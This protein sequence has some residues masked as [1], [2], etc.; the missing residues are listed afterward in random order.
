[1][2]FFTVFLQ[3]V[4]QTFLK[5]LKILIDR[6]KSGKKNA[7]LQVRAPMT[8]F[9]KC[10]RKRVWLFSSAGKGLEGSMSIEA[11]LGFSLFLFACVCM[12]A[13]MVMMDKQ[14][15]IQAD[16]ERKAEQLSQYAYLGGQG[17][18]A[19]LSD[20]ENI[21]LVMKYDMKLPFSVFGLQAIPME[22]KSVRRAWIGR[23]GPLGEEFEKGDR[24]EDKE[25]SEKMVFVG[26]NGTRYHKTASCHYLSNDIEAIAYEDLEI[27]RNGGGG[28][29]HPCRICGKRAG[30]GSTVYIMAEG[31]SYHSMR[32]CPATIAYIKEVPI[33]EVKHLGKCSYC[34]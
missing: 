5:N 8:G 7:T 28:R 27:R 6:M 9:C 3:S 25:N 22:S 31:E 33:E 1:M 29:Y 4:I 2:P 20:G 13:P 14:R 19:A 17:E 18:H 23:N 12:M 32:D 16:L 34:W 26:N 11:A 15:Q 10:R 21:K 24:E 30:K